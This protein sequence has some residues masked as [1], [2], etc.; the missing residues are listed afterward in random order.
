MRLRKASGYQR[1]DTLEPPPQG[2]S[3]GV[4][5]R[6]KE[7]PFAVRLFKLVAPN[8]DIERVGTNNFAF[9]LT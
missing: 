7:V 1:L 5:V 6:V 9:T 8:G 2:W 3:R 4:E